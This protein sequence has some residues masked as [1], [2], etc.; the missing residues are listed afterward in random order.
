[1]L[2][3]LNP[4]RICGLVAVV[5]FWWWRQQSQTTTQQLQQI[6]EY[7]QQ[8]GTVLL[9]VLLRHFLK[10]TRSRQPAHPWTAMTLQ[11]LFLL[12]LDEEKREKVQD[13]I[14]HV[15]FELPSY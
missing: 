9:L 1:M 3:D 11:V 10:Q 15:L 13:L 8:I 7:E 14:Y 6:L 2:Q 5:A 12:H 4:Q